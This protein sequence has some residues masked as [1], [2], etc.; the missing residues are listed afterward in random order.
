MGGVSYESLNEIYSKRK[1]S[2]KN[3]GT[4]TYYA[5]WNVFTY[6]CTCRNESFIV[7]LKKKSTA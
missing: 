1:K 2:G 3:V 4:I 7:F 6:V 5:C